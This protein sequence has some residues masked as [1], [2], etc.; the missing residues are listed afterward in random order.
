[1]REDIY[2]EQIAD[3]DEWWVEIM[4]YGKDFIDETKA[5]D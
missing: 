2:N 3:L 5:D 1:M 4:P